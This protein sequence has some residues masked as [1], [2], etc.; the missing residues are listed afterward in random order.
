MVERDIALAE[1]TGGP[2]HVVPHERAAVAAR[3]ARRQGARRHHVTCEVAPHHFVL[4]DEALETPIRYDTNVKMNPPLRE[5]ADR[6]AMLEGLADGTVDVIATDHAPHHADEKLV[7]F[8]RAPFGIVGL[9]TCVPLVFDRLV[10]AGR[11]GVAAAD[12][13]AVGEP[14]ARVPP[15]RRVARRGRPGRHHDAGARR[16]GH[17]FA[18]PRCES[19]SKNTPFDGWTLRGGVAATIVGGRIVYTNRDRLIDAND[20]DPNVRATLRRQ[21]LK[22][23]A[24][25][26]SADAQRAL[27]LRQRLP[28]PR[29]S[30]PA[31]A[32][33]ASVDDLASGAGSARRAARRSARADRSR[34]RP[35]DGRRA[36]RAHAGRPARRPPRADPSAVQLR[37]VQQ[38]RRPGLRAAR[39]LR[40]RRWRASACCSP[41]TCA[42]PARRSSAA[43]SSCARPAAPCW[44]RCEICDRLE[45]IVDAGV[46]NVR[47]RRIQG[48]GELPGGA[49]ARCARPASRSA[50]SE[51]SAHWRELRRSR[52]ASAGAAGRA[53]RGLQ[54]RGLRG[55]SGPDRPALQR[56]ARTGGRRL[57]RRRAGVR[58]GGRACSTRVE[59]LAAVLGARA[60]RRI[61]RTFDPA[62]PHPEL[63]AMVHRWTRG[64]DIVALLWILRQMLDRSGSIEGVLRGR[65][66]TASDR[67]S[68][69]RSTAFRAA[70]WRSICGRPTA[71]A[72]PRAAGVC[73]FFP[74]PSAG[75]ACKRLNLFLRWMVRRDAVDLG[76][77]TS[78]SPAKLIV[79]LDTHVIRLGRCLRLTRYTSPG[80]RMAADITASLRAIDPDD[81]VRFDFSLCHVGMMNACGFGRR[82][83]D[84]QC[85][86]KGM[87]RP[88]G[89]ASARVGDRRRDRC[90]RLH[91]RGGSRRGG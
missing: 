13:A 23:L 79:P 25:V 12:R 22:Q 63:R 8:D 61:V 18:R 50:R 40:A 89:R 42:I 41:T 36:A 54:P 44:R 73:Y 15:A 30:E 21:A 32:V 58:A 71:G 72:C 80:W 90:L 45:A 68:A 6:D 47:A 38:P 4:T 84:A 81:P 57:L 35:G 11:I 14:G 69:A 39:L 77:W 5:A 48:A 53:L 62:A 59:T 9:E 29:L 65:A 76:A 66:T 10:H 26:R 1:L 70:R 49:S 16:A 28:R 37:A 46:P 43:P 20:V 17:R 60:G 34:R 83:G 82:Q 88:R 3:G 33:P 56:P 64:V 51:A 91:R 31:P 2:Y 27:R 75:S 67:T 55:R 52:N 24:A 74:R 85:P 7:E 87:C 78:V 19:K 86:L